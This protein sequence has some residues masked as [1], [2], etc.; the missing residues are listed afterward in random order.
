MRHTYARIDLNALTYN[1]TLL[2]AYSPSSRVVAVVKA[3]SYGHGAIQ[4]AR[5]I[6]DDVD[7]FAVAF[8]D[9]ALDLREAGIS[10]PILIL[11]GPHQAHE[12]KLTFSE[13]LHWMVHN[14][15]QLAWLGELKERSSL[16]AHLWLKFDT[17]MH[18]LGFPIE[19][20]EKIIAEN[21]S[22]INRH[23]VIATH[24]ACADEPNNSHAATQISSFLDKA[25]AHGFALS[26]ANSAGAIEHKDAKQDYNR[27][28][29]TLYGSSPFPSD[30]KLPRLP[31]LPSE[32]SK[33]MSSDKQNNSITRPT[34]K[35]AMTLV[36]KVV[37]IRHIPKGDTVG[38]GATWQAQRQTTIA[39]VSIGYADG[40][41][42]HAPSGTPAY[43]KGQRIKL[44]GRVS[45]DMLTFDVTDHSNIDLFDEVELWGEHVSVNEV[46]EHVGTIGY[47]LMTRI[48]SRVKRK[49]QGVMTNERS[50]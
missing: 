44:V 5:H 32:L 7:M 20:F 43:C 8:I 30:Y 23:S 34:L 9:E 1:L 50:E 4:V 36:A 28:G 37:A 12:L 45:M 2:K 41:P 10:K 33:T 18:R 38:Y 35:P 27:I 48:S 21:T 13:N 46:A 26:I 47:E 17:G 14:R 15:A 3:D 39:T 31:E 16:G 19:D 24:L 25:K 6:E 40:Y 22:V 29:I 42:R 49:Y 11:Q